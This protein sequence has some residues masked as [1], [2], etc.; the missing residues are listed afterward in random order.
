[1]EFK[2]TIQDF[3]TK[4]AESVARVFEGQPKAESFQF[5][6]DL[7][8][9]RYT[10]KTATQQWRY[11][12]SVGYK[13]ASVVLTGDQ[14][15]NNVR[16][17][18]RENGIPRSD[19]LCHGL[20]A[21]EL[22]VDMETGTGKTYVYTKTIFELNRR[23]GWTKF[24]IVVPLVAIREGVAK[25]LQTTERH[26]AERY[27]KRI[28][29]FVYNSGRLNDIDA[30][31]SRDDISVMIVNIQAFNAFDESKSKEG[32]G[33]DKA[34]RIM[35]SERDDFGSR[36]PIDVLA[37]TNPILILDEPQ[38]MGKKNSSTRKAM[39]HFNPLFLLNYS[40][41]HAEKHSLVYA[42]DALD[43]YNMRLV[44]RIEVKGIEVRGMRGTDGY[45]YL[46]EIQ[47][48]KNKP[49]TASIEFKKLSASG[50]VSMATRCFI[51]GD[52]IYVASGEL[53]SY[54]N[55][56]TVAEIV[57]DQNDRLGFVR[58]RNG[59]EI[60]CGEVV[61]D[62]SAD[63]LRRV[64][65]RETI[66]S[67]LEKEERLYERGIK[68]LSLFFIDEVSKYR[69]YTNEGDELTVGYGTIFE[70]EYAAAVKERLEASRLGDESSGSYASYLSRFAPNE[71]HKGYF[72]TDKKGHVVNSKVKRGSEDSDDESAYELIMRNKERLLSFEE[73]TRFIFSHSA[74]REGW[75]NPNVFQICTLKESKS[76]TGKRQEVGRGMRLC[77]NRNGDRQDVS[78]LGE[79]MVQR[80]NLLTVIASESYSSFV[81][82]LQKDMRAQ[83]RER[84]KK[85]SEGF[86]RDFILHVEDDDGMSLHS[87]DEGDARV[88]YGFVLMSGYIDPD[89]KVADKFRDEGI[90][91]EEIDKLTEPMQQ[92]IRKNL[93]IIE[94]ALTSVYDPSA[95]EGMIGNGLEAKIVSN[96]LNDNF[97]RREFQD[98]WNRINFKQAYTVRFDDDELRRKAVDNI[99][100][101]LQ[102]SRVS[103]RLVV[104]EQEESADAEHIDA[105]SHFSRTSTT[106]K[107]LKSA[108]VSVEYDLIGEVAA[109][110]GITRRSAAVIL[111]RISPLK[112]GL[113][114]ENPEEFIAK[115]GD[116]IVDE[117]ATMVVEHI[118]YNRLNERYDSAIFTDTMPESMAR[119]YHAKKNVQ[120]YV[121]PDGSAERSVERRFAEDLDTADE[122]CVYAKLP[123][124]FQIPTP[125]GGYAPDWAIAFK[126]GSV[127]HVF[128]VA[129]TKGSM[130]SLQ[131]RGVERAKIECARKLFNEMSD[132]DVRYD[133]VDSYES[134]LGIVNGE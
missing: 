52:S 48:S 81:S 128:F 121:F 100:R 30:F 93:R 110:A 24:I 82:S 104:G 43:A 45:L 129:E 134:L 67:H 57:P 3:Q 76:E 106:T 78:A 62:S 125:V 18:Q 77:V 28:W 130:S 83:L 95:L 34:A 119:A 16:R 26:F 63:D 71:V 114:Q 7:G 115:V 38:K 21:I 66:K 69:A 9:E 2:Y 120:D 133:A 117:K 96:S 55:D 131:L 6:R 86:L 22:D 33:G 13:N 109:R 40:A 35:F 27:G 90:T 12:D 37:A 46:K 85:V 31:A 92:S 107:E 4:A 32:R 79:D 20:G 84:P 56:F 74:L 42:L 25:S 102:V 58:F 97:Y 72:S 29:W 39:K 122:V 14:L 75:D 49:P 126:A 112:F 132:G 68:C 11:E 98:L 23:Y 73:P 1:M 108:P 124:G 10:G 8:A 123:R 111:S 99:N 36:R 70:Q 103:Y 54:R 50:S 127:K 41:T 44:K 60:R 101:N 91:E 118:S 88:A 47:V 64:Q 113:F 87:M 94:A 53:E 59:E 116:A 17:I 61:G 65:I 51:E 89:G 15:L 5:V 80:V 19:S 105:G